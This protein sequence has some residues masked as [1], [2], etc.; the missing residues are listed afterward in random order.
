MSLPANFDE[1]EIRL[2]EDEYCRTCDCKPC[3]CEKLNNEEW[4]DI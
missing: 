1:D 2:D 4:R 3:E